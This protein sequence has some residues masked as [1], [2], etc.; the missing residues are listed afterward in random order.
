MAT[1]NSLHHHH[2]SSSYQHHRHNL[3]CQSHFGPTSLS[4]KQ[5]TSAATFSLI[6]SSSSSSV[7]VVSA[8]TTTNASAST[9]VTAETATKFDVLATHLINQDFRKADEETRRL[10]IQIAGEAAVKRGYV[11]FSE[12]KSISTEDLQAIDNLWTKHSDG[13]FGYSVQR[14]IWLKVK[15]D[16]SRFFIKVEWMKLLDTEVVQYNYRAFPDEFKW[17]LNDET[18]LGHLP[19][20]NALRGTQLL[21]CVLS[22]PAFVI[23]G[24]DNEEADEAENRVGPKEPKKDTRMFKTDYSF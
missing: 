7:S 4:L 19:L 3:H 13:R 17:E 8:A 24:D 20:T 15:K 10:L 21:K 2:H 22:H 14:K 18:P 6:C 11:F 9:A 12:V 1:T 5:P 23:A 16:F